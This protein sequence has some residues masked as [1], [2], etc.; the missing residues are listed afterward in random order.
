MQTKM[1]TADMHQ[2]PTNSK[3]TSKRCFASCEAQSL[4]STIG[5]VDLETAFTHG[6]SLD[7]QYHLRA[8][9][10]D[11]KQVV[12]L[13]IPSAQ[14]TDR[15][16]IKRQWRIT[17]WVPRW[18]DLRRGVGLLSS[19][20]CEWRGIHMMR[21]AGLNVPE[22][23][24]LFWQGR[25]WSRAAVVIKAVPPVESLADMIERGDIAELS[26]RDTAGLVDTIVAVFAKLDESQ[27]AWRSMKA[28]HFYPEQL[29]NGAWSI[30]LIDCE[31]VHRSRLRKDRERGR[32]S[33]VNSLHILKNEFAL[34]LGMCA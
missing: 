7:G 4:L 26:A 13:P 12:T 8:T 33:F 20:V 27:L 10:H 21:S 6:E 9:R 30:W 23:L 15:L 1:P 11:H 24:A 3:S 34:R 14:G 25:G 28:K 22:P 19:P 2:P 16:Y 5:L 17:R 29:P 31:G 32:R 18:T